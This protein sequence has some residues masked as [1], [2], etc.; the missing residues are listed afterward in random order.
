MSTVN[1]EAYKHLNKFKE[2]KKARQSGVSFS[3]VLT[4]SASSLEALVVKG[5][6][7]FSSYKLSHSAILIKH[8]KGNIL[9]DTGLGRNIEEQY[10]K[11]MPS[12]LKPFTNYE[13]T[14]DVLTQLNTIGFTEDSIDLIIPSH[15]HWDHVSGLEDFINTEIFITKEEK[16]WANLEEESFNG[17]MKSQ[18]D[19]PDIKWNYFEFAETP[20]ENF[21][22]SYDL[23]GDG[24]IIL[25]PLEGHTPGSVALLL[26]THYG[27][28]CLFTGD[29]SWSLKGLKLPAEKFSISADIADENQDLL[30]ESL[31]RVYYLKKRYPELRLVPAH[32]Y[33]VQ[34]RIGFFPKFIK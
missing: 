14:N 23:F 33:E 21:D 2:Q 1:I 9:F 24:S 27:E 8:P 6:S 13:L 25:L 16:V 32:D 29:L 26:T 30:R 10:K 15:L 20:Y 4:G 17:C 19:D 28:K 18:F 5:G 11:E 31:A 22:R 3:I 34:K 7:L 12:E